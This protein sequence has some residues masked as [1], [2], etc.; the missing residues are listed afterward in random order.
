[1]E[2]TATASPPSGAAPSRAAAIALTAA[3][4][5]LGLVFFAS[6]LSG[7]VLLFMPLP[8][9]PPG[10]AATFTDVFF[11]SHWVQFVDG[12]EFAAGVLLL[13]NRYVPLAL[14]LLGAVIA[15]IFFFHISMQPQALP[16][17]VLVLALWIAVAWQRRANL[18]PLF[19]E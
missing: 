15:N 8:P 4:I 12:V 17:P 19:E 2:R 1:M 11:R 9:S 3:R 18:R 6:G 5:L 7:F 14:V 16:I 13:A 10:L